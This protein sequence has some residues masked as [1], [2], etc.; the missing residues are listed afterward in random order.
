LSLD[1]LSIALNLDVLFRCAS[2]DS[3]H[4]Q[5][6]KLFPPVSSNDLENGHDG[7]R[8]DETISNSPSSSAILSSPLK[9][10]LAKFEDLLTEVVQR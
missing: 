9:I 4:Y 6:V 8:E 2:T 3:E 10:P 1:Y 7:V 5:I